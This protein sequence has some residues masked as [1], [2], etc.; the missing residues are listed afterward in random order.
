MKLSFSTLGCP[1]WSFGEIVL[2]ASQYGYEGVAFRGLGG[3]LD[4]TKVP[5]FFPA[6]RANTRRRLKEAGLATSMVLTSA[7]MMIADAEKLEAIFNLA[8]AIPISP[9]IWSA[10]ISGFWR[11]EARWHLVRCGGLEGWR[12]IASTGRL[13]RATGCA[14]AD[15]NSRRLGCDIAIASGSRNGEPSQRR[16]PLG[17]TP[18]GSHCGRICGPSLGEYRAL[19]ALRGFEGLHHRLRGAPGIPVRPD[20]GRRNSFKDALQTLQAAGYDGWLTFEWE[21]LWHP[22]LA[23]PSVAFPEFVVRIRSLLEA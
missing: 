20:W 23:D 1:G 13:R 10:R 11:A 18:P 15:R 2:R 9:L 7:T 12:T 14:R 3:Q 17:R 6:A 5:E 22:N 21:K 8:R 19:G 4:L 16:H